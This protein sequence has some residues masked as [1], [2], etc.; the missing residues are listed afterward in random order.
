[1]VDIGDM[2][3]HGAVGGIGRASAEMGGML[4]MAGK[5]GRGVVDTVDI[6]GLADVL[7]QGQNYDGRVAGGGVCEY[8]LRGYIGPMVWQGVHL[9][10]VCC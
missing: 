2:G 7:G 9:R 1:M 5:S 10:G 4:E 3:A 6:G 8:S